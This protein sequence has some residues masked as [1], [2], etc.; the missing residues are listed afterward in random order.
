MAFE[1]IINFA[2]SAMHTASRML[3]RLLCAYFSEKE[4]ND[5]GKTSLKKKKE[6]EQLLK[7]LLHEHFSKEEIYVANS[8]WKNAHHH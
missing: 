4:A 1:S 6:R 5:V 2:E 3:H 8:I 7:H